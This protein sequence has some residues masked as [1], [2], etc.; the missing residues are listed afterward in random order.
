MTSSAPV[1]DADAMAR[2]QLEAKEILKRAG[3]F[4]SPRLRVDAREWLIV[5]EY[6]AGSRLVHLRE[7]F[8]ERALS[9][10]VLADDGND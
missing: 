9:R 1:A 10:A 7:Q 3:H 2:P 6:L 5:D 4:A 8:H